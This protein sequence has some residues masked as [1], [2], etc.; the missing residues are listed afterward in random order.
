MLLRLDTNSAHPLFIQ[1]A[2]AIRY[3]ILSGAKPP[4]SR[5]PAAKSLAD[6]LDI[7]VHTVLRSYQLLRDDK[8]IELRRGRGATVCNV[9][10]GTSEINVLAQQIVD[11]AKKHQMDQETVIALVR[12]KFRS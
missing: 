11:L 3:E 9:G 8:L 6:A 5:L 1:L 12:G 7:N 2:D 10:Q 4:G